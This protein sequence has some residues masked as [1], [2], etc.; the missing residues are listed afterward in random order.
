MNYNIGKKLR[1]ER[2]KMAL[3]QDEFAKKFGFAR[4]HI[5]ALESGRKKV[6]LRT[7]EKLCKIT[8]TDISFWIGNI[9][10]EKLE[11]RATKRSLLAIDRIK[12]IREKMHLTQEEF[13]K[14][15]GISREY[16]R[17]I[18]I[19][20]VQGN[21]DILIRLSNAT[22]RP[23]QYF[24]SY[25]PNLEELPLEEQVSMFINKSRVNILMEILIDIGEVQ[26]GK[27]SDRGMEMLEKLFSFEI[28]KR[29][30]EKEN[31]KHE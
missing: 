18:E 14:K 8:N 1:E 26:N 31:E 5:S 28:T 25:Y 19:G 24:L 6:T 9:N 20:K 13:A 30:K 2:K 15:I 29:I 3:T 21:I 27:M 11:K 7:V 23:I 12:Y 22:N 17:D 4:S 10:E 16:L